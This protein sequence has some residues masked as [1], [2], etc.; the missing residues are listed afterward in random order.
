MLNYVIAMSVVATFFGGGSVKQIHTGINPDDLN[1]ADDYVSRST[2]F[3]P[4]NEFVKCAEVRGARYC[5]SIVGF[6][7]RKFYPPQWDSTI[8]VGYLI[9]F[10]LKAAKKEGISC[11]VSYQQSGE[12]S[13]FPGDF[14]SDRV[15]QLEYINRELE[16]L[17]SHTA[18]LPNEFYSA[19]AS[20]GKC[21]L[22]R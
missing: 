17:S 9:S 8:Y 6:E 10:N 2:N 14:F 4:T 12:F 19:P 11:E 7:V 3:K 21:K 18:I 1:S 20:L 16:Q 5:S 22:R 13:H 15:E